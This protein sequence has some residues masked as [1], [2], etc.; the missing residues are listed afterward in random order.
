MH[1]RFA[2]AVH[3]GAGEREVRPRAFLQAHDVL[4]EADGVVELAGPDVEMI[5]RAYTHAHAMS[6]LFCEVR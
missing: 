4:I 5:E 3:P 1:D 6:P 2:L